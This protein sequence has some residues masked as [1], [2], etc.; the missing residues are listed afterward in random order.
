MS[1]PSCGRT[2]NAT[3]FCDPCGPR[4]VS[5]PGYSLESLI[6]QGGSGQVFKARQVA[7]GRTVCVKR[8]LPAV[9]TQATSV[10]RFRSEALAMGRVQHPNVV[11]VYDVPLGA[12]RLPFIVME[13]VEGRSL[14]S[15]IHDEAPLESARALDLVDQ[16]LAGLE[17]C[18]ARGVVHRDLKPTNVMVSRLSDGREWCK[19]LDFGIAKSQ[20]HGESL[21]MTGMV[22]GTPGYM[23]PEQIVAQPV[24]ARADVF[25]VG[26]VLFELLTGGR[27]FRGS[28]ADKMRRTVTEDAPGAA[29][30]VDSLPAELDVVCRRALARDVNERF[31]DASAFRS[32]L[33][34]V[35]IALARVEE[36]DLTPPPVPRLTDVQPAPLPLTP[37]A[38]PDAAPSGPA[39]PPAPSPLS[40][41]SRLEALAQA[42]L[43]ASSSLALWALLDQFDTRLKAA[44][45][46]CQ[47]D[48]LE[49]LRQ[50]E[51]VLTAPLPFPALEARLLERFARGLTTSLDGVFELV[52]RPGGWRVGAWLLTK[53]GA[54]AAEGLADRYVSLPESL[55]TRLVKVLWTRATV[56]EVVARLVGDSSR[57]RKVVEGLD[58]V[59]DDLRVFIF[60]GLLESHDE[61]V[62]LAALDALSASLGLR[63][64][65]SIRGRLRDESAAVR[66]RAIA[67]V[68]HLDDEA[69]VPNLARILRSTDSTKERLSVVQ[70]L[71]GLGDAGFHLLAERLAVEENPTV[72]FSIAEA[73][74]R[75]GRDAGFER[76]AM[77]ANDA[78]TPLVNRKAMERALAQV[79]V[80]STPRS[81]DKADIAR[82]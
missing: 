64:T 58:A 19:L 47:F 12:D 32:A 37:A 2:S 48:E 21:T 34:A 20:A 68:V 39:A 33:G 70:A 25:A 78:R 51:D 49:E 36:R 81:E 63:F 31:D 75:Q 28:D 5:F 82:L 80:E 71:S 59:D 50:R 38:V 8:L 10:A 53:A 72:S 77:L 16:L 69:S 61:H 17:A 9:A 22:V 23:A 24:D 7:L 66:A 67:W 41:P 40:P 56:R 46:G 13:Y 1:C 52:S 62:R 3:E 57:A 35:R 76:V 29:T 44:V 4:A 30:R 43:Q 18:H 55:R 14:R 42:A 11:A 74:L 45:T 15:I 26:V 6:G 27:P 79:P 54:A 73:L 65:V 60:G